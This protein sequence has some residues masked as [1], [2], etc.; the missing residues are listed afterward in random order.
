MLF[1]R[2]EKE[3][4]RSEDPLHERVSIHG[5]FVAPVLFTLAILAS[6]G[7]LLFIQP[8]LTRVV[9]PLAG[10]APGVWTTAMFFFQCVAIVAYLY[11]HLIT[12]LPRIRHQIGI[13]LMLWL[14][15]TSTLPLGVPPGWTPD[16][17]GSLQLQTLTLYA[18]TVGLPFLFLSASAPLIQTWYARTRGPSAHDPYFLSGASNLGALIALL[19]FPL[20]AEPFFEIPAI[21][22][23]WSATFIGMGGLLFISAFATTRD[24]PD[25]RAVIGVGQRKSDLQTLWRWGAMAF[26]PASLMLS[27]TTRLATDFGSL[28]L[29]WVVPLSIYLISYVAGFSRR[30]RTP[31]RHAAFAAPPAMAVLAI[32]GLVSSA[33]GMTVPVSAAMMVATA[34]VSYQLHHRL[35]EMRPDSSRLT[36]FYMAISIGAAAAGFFNAILAPM[37]MDGMHEFTLTLL[38]ACGT[39]A[40]GRDRGGPSG[41]H[42]LLPLVA[43]L[44]GLLSMDTDMPMLG[45]HGLQALLAAMFVV[46]CGC[47]YNRLTRSLGLFVFCLAA[48]GSMVLVGDVSVIDRSRNFFGLHEVR[49]ANGTRVLVTGT[50]RRGGQSATGAPLPPYTAADPLGELAMSHAW[51]SARR[52]GLV[53]L[54]AGA[55][56]SWAGDDQQVVAYEIDPEVIRIATDADM[57]GFVADRSGRTTIHPGDAR[58]ALEAGTTRPFGVLVIDAYTSEM[59]PMNLS[60]VEAMEIFMEDVLEGGMLVY[61]LTSRFFDLAEPL[62]AAAEHLG[63]EAWYKRGS[64]DTSDRSPSPEALIVTRRG[65]RPELVSAPGSGWIRLRPAPSRAWHDDIASPFTAFSP[66]G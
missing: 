16:P 54:G 30:L 27:F 13:H 2:V 3:A 25:A 22:L 65:E 43:V 19:G 59:V 58:L 62:A 28:P 4:G 7:L 32:G 57:F 18:R 29:I 60:T 51:Q 56:V 47:V 14:I 63:Y 1:T 39:L 48:A 12:R 66:R 55:M 8:L 36:V 15:A 61:H 5:R 6:A 34:V 33:H 23:G 42:L 20:V 50:S 40:M 44:F 11:A 26:V 46:A 52:I 31:G 45:E 49:D 17:A 53:G 10:G 9:T 21:S 41:R 38:A 35:Y 37:L 24:H 64:R